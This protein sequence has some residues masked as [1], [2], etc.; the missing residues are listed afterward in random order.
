MHYQLKAQQLLTYSRIRMYRAF[1]ERLAADPNVRTNG[2]S[3]LFHFMMLCSRAN[4]RT[5]RVVI[6]GIRYS[7]APGE[8]LMPVKDLTRLFRCKTD[9]ST[10]ALLEELQAKNLIG[11]T[12]LHRGRYVK[13]K[14]LNWHQ[15]NT[16][17]EDTAS[18]TKE[19]G[20][21][22]F[23][24]SMVNDFMGKGKCSE[25]DIVLDLWINAVYCDSHIAG[26]A[27]GPVVYFRNG[28]HSPLIGYDT[29]GTRWGISKSTT[30][31]V[32]RKLQELGYVELIAFPGKYGTAIYMK[33]YLPTMFEMPEMVIDR[34]DV[35][36]SLHI[37]IHVSACRN[38]QETEENFV[39]SGTENT[40]VPACHNSEKSPVS[41]QIVVPENIRCVP[42]SHLEKIVREVIRALSLQEY[43]CAS[44]A[45]ARYI[46]SNLSPISNLSDDCKR[47][48]IF[49]ELVM[50]CPSQKTYHRFSLEITPQPDEEDCPDRFPDRKAG[51]AQS[52]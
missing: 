27:E 40:P 51:D 13:Y 45:R 46:L 26:S 16:A 17:V 28:S 6:D 42:K 18:C 12:L 2:E 37:E 5:S 43:T 30:G 14:I 52:P 31:R 36:L 7:V 9:K 34:E 33:N 41:E 50:E 44:C 48:T 22:F 29:L 19:D 3:Y 49:T 47:K 23:P 38:E 39:V 8:W 24:Y 1:L 20:F 11:F 21:F 4:F 35:A 15:F 32:L 25:M 10:L